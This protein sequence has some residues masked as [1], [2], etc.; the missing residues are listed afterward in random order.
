[1]SERGDDKTAMSDSKTPPAKAGGSEPLA[2]DAKRGRRSKRRSGWASSNSLKFLARSIVLEE[3]G[4]PKALRA[5]MHLMIVGVFCFIGWASIT[6]L[7]ETAR[8]P[9]QVVPDGSVIAVQH[10]EGGIVSDILVKDGTAVEKDAVIIRLDKTA[11]TAELEEKKARIAALSLEAERHRAFADGRVPNF[12]GVAAKY[13]HLVDDNMAIYK[14]QTESRNHER[15]VL[16]RQIDQR[17]SELAVLNEQKATIKEQIGIARELTQMRG[18]LMKSGHISRVVYL[19]T[20]QELSSAEGELREVLG[21]IVKANQALAEAKGKL[22]ET[23]AKLNNEAATEMARVTSELEQL[24]QS[25][26]R[27]EDRVARTDIRAPVHGIVKGLQVRSI[28]AVIP[29]GGVISEIVPINEELVVEARIS[30]TDIGHIKVG[31]TAN[32]VITTYDFARFGSIE[33]QVD[34]ISATTFLEENGNV[35]YKVIVKLSHNFVGDKPGLNLIVPGMITE[36]AINTGQ[37]TLMNYL[38]RPVYVA[39]N[40]AFGER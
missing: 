13:S 2:K 28:G 19:R 3:V 29:P 31:Q 23:E 4:P 30:P 1:M 5:T 11:A 35:F 12:S 7:T 36:V 14:L 39:L 32:V 34:K 24:R 9:G 6:P 20:K 22:A 38:L 27:L 18:K 21:K 15:V 25:V 10:L 37:R 8:A 40:R 26:Q 16:Q 17:Q 33:G